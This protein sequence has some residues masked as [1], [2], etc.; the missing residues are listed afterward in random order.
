VAA[1][2]AWIA[3]GITARILAL[4]GL[5]GAVARRDPAAQEAVRRL[6]RNL[7]TLG[8]ASG[9]RQM[10]PEAARLESAGPAAM[11]QRLSEFLRFLRDFAREEAGGRLRLLLVEPDV[12]TARLLEEALDAPTRTITVAG[13]IAAALEVVAEQEV[14]LI[15]LE[16]M[17]PDGDG[18]Q[19]LGRLR[20]SPATAGIP[21]FVLAPRVGDEPRAECYALGADALFDKPPNTAVI[22]AAVASRLQR[23]GEAAFEARHDP[24][25]GLPNR[26]A[27][28]E[29]FD[30]LRATAVRTGAPM[31]IALLRLDPPPG[32]PPVHSAYDESLRRTAS[33]LSLGLRDTDLV[34][35][36]G[37]DA[38]IL[39]LPRAR[40]ADGRR[41]LEKIQ[42]RLS[43]ERVHGEGRGQAVSCTAGIVD[44]LPGQPVDMLLNQADRLVYAGR[45]A[46][47][48]RLLVGDAP[49]ALPERR[50]LLAQGDPYTAGAISRRLERE[51]FL[52]L[53][54]SDGVSALQRI[55]ATDVSLVIVD[56]DL[57]R[58]DGFSLVARLRGLKGH[59]ETPVLMLAGLGEEAHIVRAFESGADDYLLKPFASPDLIARVRRLLTPRRS[60][61]GDQDAPAGS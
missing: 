47:G 28:Y 6:A 52:V 27:F 14:A 59:G 21:V 2:R 1:P 40:A 23:A 61:T 56:V 54:C 18:R 13:S 57:P 20:E 44:V 34:A 38:F 19:L 5:E 3:E 8:I 39:A 33:I 45:S 42:E 41:A 11:P 50:I 30:R 16:L 26:A 4:E 22:A 48:R 17:L 43:A 12:L 24:L 58:L 49:L 32:A 35:R 36:W 46:G 25:T 29:S 55:D 7:R 37:G 10:G 31:C 15:L 9:S 51:G 60:R 53:H